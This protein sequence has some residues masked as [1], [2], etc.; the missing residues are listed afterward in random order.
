MKSLEEESEVVTK[1]AEKIEKVLKNIEPPTAVAAI[2]YIFLK[3]V[4]TQAEG[5]TMAKA[6][7]AVFF[8]NVMNSVNDFYHG[9]EGDPI[10]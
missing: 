4:L 3:M 1:T 2:N 8:N 5:P 10:H 6:M 9:N 7:A